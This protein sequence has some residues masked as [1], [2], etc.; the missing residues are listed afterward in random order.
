ME[1]HIRCDPND[2]ARYCFT[3][4]D[5]ER[6]RKIAQQFDD[7]RFITDSRGY[8]VY[9][10]HYQDVFMTVCSTGMGGPTTAIAIEELAHMGAD[11][12]IRVGSCGVLQPQLKPGD[13]IISSGTVRLGGTSN[14]Y[15]PV[16][17]PAVPTFQVTHALVEAAEADNAPI[18]IGLNVTTDAFYMEARIRQEMAKVGV[19][20][21]EMESDTLFIVGHVRGLRTGA[22]FA[23]DG[24]VSEVKPA[25]GDEAFRMGEQQAIAIALRAMHSLALADASGTSISSPHAS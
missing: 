17:F 9:S 18:H 13:I 22:L 25:W 3:P 20:A 12:F 1:L 15:L 23:V 14:A 16:E 2:I 24:T 5:P 11:T 4:G 6:T 7:S 10:G 8:L 19:L 21:I